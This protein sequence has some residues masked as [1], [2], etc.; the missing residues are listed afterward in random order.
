M[1]HVTCDRWNVI[2]GGGWTFSQ[3]L[4]SLAL[5]VWD[6]QCLQDSE[7]KGH[8]IN[9]LNNHQGVYKRALA[10]L[11]LLNTCYNLGT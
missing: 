7:Q 8:S 9:K 1:W 5:T 6:R 10:T 4:S 2:H 3:N 11:G